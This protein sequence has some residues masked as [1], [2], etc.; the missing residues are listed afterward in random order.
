MEFFGREKELEVLARE[1]ELSLTS[2]RFTIIMGR[3]RIGKTYL[4]RRS[5]KNTPCLYILAKNEAEATFCASLQR[6]IQRELNIPIYGTIRSMRD[7]FEIL[8]SYATKEH[9][10][11]VIDEVQEFFY[12]RKS[13]FADMQELWDQYKSEMKINF[14]TCGSI[15]SLMKELFEDKKA[16]MYGRLTK[17]IEL[18][19]FSIA[20][21][22]EILRHYLP[23]YRNEDLL[24]LYMLTGGVAKYIETLI[25]EQAFTKQKML[26]CFINA[27][28]PFLT[29]G[30]DLIN[31]EFRRESAIYY[32]ILSLIADGKNTSGEIDSI[33]ETTSSAYLRNLEINYSLVRKVRP[34]FASERSRGIRYRLNDNFLQFWFRFIY[35]NL[36]LVESQRSDLLLEIIEQGYSVYSGFVL[37]RYFQ[38]RIREEERFS[39]IGNWWDSKGENE[40]D[41]V[42][43]NRIDR[44]ARIAE[45]KINPRKISLHVLE[46]K[47]QKLLG[48]LKRYRIEYQ[49]YSL[50]DM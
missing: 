2:A 36:D 26:E 22:K 29:E 42:A 7:I 11:L 8:F 49:G 15:Y 38:Q 1:Q 13:I 40:I 48:E 17:R 10:N 23:S 14:I 41:I 28:M 16:A 3:R 6:Q 24:C 4:I 45:V 31:M 44:Q 30:T 33:L 50:E 37:E 12:V 19:P 47:A 5:F 32:S 27:Y 46:Q 18:L 34:V 21:M 43:I 25:D 35:P 9:L 20:T 39:L